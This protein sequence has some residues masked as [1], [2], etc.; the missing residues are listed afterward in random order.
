MFDPACSLRG[1][2]EN[3]H[4]CHVSRGLSADDVA[5]FIIPLGTH[6]LTY[7]T[8]HDGTMPKMRLLAKKA[9]CR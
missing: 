3:L 5:W 6:V 8:V 4:I 1:L 7:K 9:K 2:L